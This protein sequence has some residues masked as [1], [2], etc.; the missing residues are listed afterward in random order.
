MNFVVFRTGGF[1]KKRERKAVSEARRRPFFSTLLGFRHYVQI[2]HFVPITRRQVIARVGFRHCVQILNYL[3]FR[4]TVS[5]LCFLCCFNR[6]FLLIGLLCMCCVRDLWHADFGIDLAGFCIQRFQIEFGSCLKPV[7]SLDGE[8][9]VTLGGSII[10][11]K[12]SS[13]IEL[14]GL[15][16]GV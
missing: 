4:R 15:W 5:F 13:F 10:K 2:C 9:K 3:G 7:R 14:K 6:M 8:W 12:E 11:T 1:D 16:I